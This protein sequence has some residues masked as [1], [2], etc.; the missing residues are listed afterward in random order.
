MKKY[1]L[2]IV[3][4]LTLLSIC[5]CNKQE[6][7]GSKI[8]GMYKTEGVSISSMNFANV[9]NFINYNTVEFFVIYSV[10][11]SG[12][13]TVPGHSDWYYNHKSTYTYYIEDNKIYIPLD[14]TILTIVDNRKLVK[15]GGPTFY[16]W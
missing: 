8:S 9:Y 11:G 14:G 4:T 13:S 1:L 7:K 15:D 16:K 5:S 10:G 6:T 12:Y 2:F 3:A